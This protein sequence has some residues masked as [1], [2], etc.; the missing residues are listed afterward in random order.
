MVPEEDEVSL[1]VESNHSSASKFGLLGEERRQKSSNP[2]S[3]FRVEI[4][5]DKFRNMLSGYGMVLNLLLILHTGD[6]EYC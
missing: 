6:F 2:N 4:I 1:V 5:Q 3:N